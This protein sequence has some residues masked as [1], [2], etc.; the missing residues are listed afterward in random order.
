VRLFLLCLAGIVSVGLVAFGGVGA[1]VGFLDQRVADQ[2][3]VVQFKRPGDDCGG[4]RQM[5]VD[6]TDGK[7]LAC[8]PSYALSGR[9]G[10]SLSGFTEAQNDEVR[11]LAEE[12]GRDGLSAAEQR[13]IQDRVDQILTTVPAAERPDRRPGLWGARQ[14][15]LCGALAM[16]G[17]LGIITVM[18]LASR[19]RS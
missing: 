14:A 2:T 9:S 3:Y 16:A 19:S 6:V 17:V 18:I 1:L 12:L 7:T 15:W 11:A 5:Y 4:A 10:T 13:E 8:R